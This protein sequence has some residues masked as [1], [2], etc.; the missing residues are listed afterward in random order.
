MGR[1]PDDFSQP[2]RGPARA[3]TEGPPSSKDGT[4]HLRPDFASLSAFTAP[5]EHQ[6]A[7]TP[8]TP[9]QSV[10]KSETQSGPQH[11]F[12]SAPDRPLTRVRGSL[13]GP[14]T[15]PPSPE[16]PRKPG[17]PG[18]SPSR[19]PSKPAGG[20]AGEAKRVVSGRSWAVELDETSGPSAKPKAGAI[21]TAVPVFQATRMI[22]IAVFLLAVFG[23]ILSVW[24]E[25]VFLS[26]PPAERP[27][28]YHPLG[29]HEVSGWADDRHDEALVTFARSCDAI[30]RRPGDQAFNASYPILGSV[31]DWQG[32]CSK[33]TA[34]LSASAPVTPAAA[35]AFFEQTF[36]PARVTR[37]SAILS[38][39]MTGYYEPELNGSLEPTEIYSTPILGL[40]DDLVQVD[41]GTFRD[42]LR[43]RRVAGRVENGRLV[44]YDDRA[45]IQYVNAQTP[46][47]VLAWVDSP[48]DAFFLHIQGS[49]RLLLPN[50][51]ALRVG[52]A[53]QN[54]HPYTA[55]GRVLI[56]E[57]SLPREGMS[58]QTIKA[59]LA[60]NPDRAEEVMAANASYIFFR[61]LEIGDGLDGPLGAQGVSLTRERS[62]AVDARFHAY[63]TPL[64]LETTVPDASADAMPFRRLMIAQDTGG[65][66][67]GPMRGDIFFGSG[68]QAGERAGRMNAPGRFL[69]LLPKALPGARAQ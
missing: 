21:I 10:T 4:G 54:G 56:E 18:L 5:L 41:L 28:T 63:G 27:L 14:D 44:P 22:L 49:G 33:A 30:G 35:R 60:A 51:T 57:G 34:L 7:R 3:R 43:G 29:W 24:V 50:G 64:W 53:G 47:N 38:G 20:G 46:R 68:A 11:K 12:Q 62:L 9:P 66:I 67:R 1:A 69:V 23:A 31:G 58:M 61:T 65:A 40:P 39:R 13:M 19:K 42:D 52:Y 32:A 36:F 26:G 16:Q 17:K 8:A 6:G 2:P 45:Q 25:T 59:W 48:V 37:G 55:I 15:L